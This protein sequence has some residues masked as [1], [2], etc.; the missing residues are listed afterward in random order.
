M[1]LRQKLKTAGGRIGKGLKRGW[2]KFVK[3]VKG[4]NETYD[5]AKQYVSD[6]QGDIDKAKEIARK[7]GGKYGGKTADAVEKA[8]GAYRKG[9]AYIDKKRDQVREVAHAVKN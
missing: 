2:R 7:Y 4:A 8:E 3:F 6:H 1:K 5:K 9:T